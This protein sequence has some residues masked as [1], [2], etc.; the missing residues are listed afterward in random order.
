MDQEKI[1]LQ[2]DALIHKICQKFVSINSQ[3]YQ[4]CLIQAKLGLIKAINT[5]DET[6]NIKFI[7]HAYNQIYFSVKKYIE[8]ENNLI[9]IPRENKE[10]IPQYIELPL[11]LESKEEFNNMNNN[12]ILKD[13]ICTLSSSEQ[14][15][16]TD[17][18]LNG[19]SP[20]ELSS[21]LKIDVNK[22]YKTNS[23]S[24]LKLRK[25]FEDQGLDLIDF[26]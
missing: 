20:A 24:I 13:A 26:L 5:F 3:D 18:Y 8:R 21:K 7:T 2:Y 22:V 9:A 10:I 12:K 6:R 11:E 25:Y 15:I 1:L 23:K 19:I 14:Q 17:I 4:D 16:V